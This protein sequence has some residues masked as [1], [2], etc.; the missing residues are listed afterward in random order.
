M[1]SIPRWKQ[2]SGIYSAN[3]HVTCYYLFLSFQFY[4]SSSKICCH[5]MPPIPFIAVLVKS[6]RYNVHAFVNTNTARTTK[7]R[8]I[9][10]TIS[11]KKSIFSGRTKAYIAA[12]IA[13]NPQML[14]RT[15]K[16]IPIPADSSNMTMDSK[17]AG[18]ST[19]LRIAAAE[20]ICGK[21]T[22]IF[23]AKC[24][25]IS[26][27]ASTH[28]IPMEN[29]TVT[30]KIRKYGILKTPATTFPSPDEIP[31]ARPDAA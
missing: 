3:N 26:I 12:S 20:I 17:M 21:E 13:V 9:M 29:N 11:T 19:A 4:I 18:T 24:P 28:A 7:N 6:G 31:S 25:A 8:I 16:A 30:R 10:L 22:G 2:S 1:L 23:N 5:D 15:N 14:I 27:S